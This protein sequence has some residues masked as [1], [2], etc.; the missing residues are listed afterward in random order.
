MGIYISLP[1]KTRRARAS[2]NSRE[3]NKKI[4]LVYPRRNPRA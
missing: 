2:R 3:R 1:G 4:S